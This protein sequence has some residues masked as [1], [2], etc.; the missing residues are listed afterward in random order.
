M[1]VSDTW[2]PLAEALLGKAELSPNDVAQQSG[3]SRDRAGRLWRALGFPPV[4]DDER[5]F[6]R[7][8]VEVLRAVQHLIDERDADPAGRRWRWETERLHLLQGQV[9]EDALHAGHGP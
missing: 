4:A 8:D 1:G 2:R 7:A 3:I 5:V 9:P 6:T